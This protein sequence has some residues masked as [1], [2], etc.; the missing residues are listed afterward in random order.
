MPR[1]KIRLNYKKERVILSDTLPYEIPIT[2]TN[3]HLYNFITYNHIEYI[4]GELSWKEN[5]QTLDNIIHI[6]FSLPKEARNLKKIEKQI[7][8][9]SF[10]FNIYTL[11]NRDL[12][13]V[14]FDF[15]IS[16]KYKEF[17]NLSIPH[18]RSQLDVA[19]FYDQYKEL[20]IYYCSLSPFSIR[21]PARVA[22]YKYHKDRLHYENLATDDPPIEEQ[23]KEYENLKSFFSYDDFSN[24]YKFFGSHTHH[25]CEKKYNKMLKLDITKCFDSIYTHSLSWAIFGKNTVKDNIKLSEKTFSGRFDNLIRNLNYQETNGIVIGPEFSRIFAE[26]ILQAVDKSVYRKLNGEIPPISHKK[27]YEIFRYVDDYFLFYNEESHKD[28]I[29]DYLQHSLKEYKLHLNFSKV[30]I[31]EKPIITEISIAKKKIADLFDDTIKYNLDKRTDKTEK[32][33]Y[34]GSI[35]IN[36]EQLITSFKTIIKECNVEYKDLLN[37]GLATIESKSKKILINFNKTSNEY[38]PFK[39][40][41]NSIQSILEFVFFIYSVSP[42]VNTTIRL[43][44][45]L[46]IY[47]EFLRSPKVNN[48]AKSRIFKYIFDNIC[49]ILNKNKNSKHIQVETLYLLVTLSELGKYFWLEQKQLAKYC[50]IK[51][52]ERDNSFEIP[53]LNYFS[54]TVLLFYMKDKK[55][56]LTLRNSII[57]KI[58]KKLTTRPRPDKN[59]ESVMLLFDLISCPYI[60]NDT[61][62][63]VLHSRG[64]TDHQEQLDVI[65]YKDRNGM[66]QLWFTTWDNFNLGLE[67]DTKQSLEV[68]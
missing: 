20:I 51:H 23:N 6:L 12:S 19:S 55:R 10:S 8:P 7:G 36:T 17:R 11:K 41:I 34:T 43:C 67:L 21:K 42:R 28:I 29:V 58:E 2:F 18:P 61:K 50:N 22:T 15:K 4:D 68:Y 9:N 26:L 3:R 64:I 35:Y 62:K 65:N 38:R 48:E 37:Y 47:C 1:K 63:R 14:P 57:S 45:I 66:R 16:H 24:I 44:R 27:D 53:E 39:Q 25:R 30:V 46:R 54:Y 52:S 13:L 60:P 32:T 49:F 56:Y 59:C 40:L 31:Y 5:S 33:I